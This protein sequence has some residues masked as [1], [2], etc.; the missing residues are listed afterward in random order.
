MSAGERGLLV[1]NDALLGARVPAPTGHAMS[2]P[3]GA[4]EIKRI[5]GMDEEATPGTPERPWPILDP[6]ALYGLLG[7]VVR[8]I[9]P[10]TE[11]DPV[12]I[13]TQFMCAAG[14][15]IGRGPHYRVE[16]D[17]HGA[18]LF[19]VLVGVTAKGRKGTSW[20]RV[21]EVMEIA[22][23]PWTAERVHS[24]LSSG[25][26]VIWAVRDPIMGYE[27]MGKGASAERVW[28]QIDPG[29]ADK[30]LMLIEPE[31]AGALTVMRREGNIVSRV[32]RDAWDRG[33]LATLTKNS[34]TRATGAHVSIIG[35]ITE[36][37]LRATLD[38]VS[39]ANGYAN[40]F[41]W[42]MVRRAQ[43]LP[44]GGAL[45]G[46]TLTELGMRTRAAIEAARNIERI[47]MT[48]DARDA[49]RRVYPV[50]SEGKPGILGA[51]TARAE[52]QTIRLA[53]VFAL[54][55]RRAEIGLD[56]LRAALAIWEFAESSSEY[57]WKDALGDPIADEILQALRNA[58]AVGLTRTAIRDLFGRHRGA[59]QIGRALAA[60]AAAGK[61]RVETRSDTGGRPVELWFAVSADR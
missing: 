45:D 2:P 34:P 21:R 53:V 38:S 40:R 60:L 59:D 15:A 3:D 7:D 20:G 22:E 8:A 17:G 26:G 46:E 25:E 33:D 41:L 14:N 37:E 1:N 48:A 16:G 36:S 11:A 35:H 55:D 9:A 24:G 49:W 61:A 56:H 58:V 50:L 4:A 31:F 10:H 57:I 23:H 19:A 42:F 12:A 18:N 44:F 39:I 51:I 47:T 30:R 32:I 6:A 28:V 27:K 43:V 52:A 54:L 13:L 5:V 29:I